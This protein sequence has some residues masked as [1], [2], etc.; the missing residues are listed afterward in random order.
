MPNVVS[1]VSVRLLVGKLLIYDFCFYDINSTKKQNINERKGRQ[2]RSSNRLKNTWNY[3]KKSYSWA[4]YSSFCG[5]DVREAA[6][7]GSKE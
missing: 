6:A 3:I 2:Q 1:C 4:F 7:A 5:R